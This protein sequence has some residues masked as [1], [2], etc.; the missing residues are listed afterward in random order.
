M[1]AKLEGKCIYLCLSSE[2]LWKIDKRTKKKHENRLEEFLVKQYRCQKSNI[3]TGKTEELQSRVCF[4]SIY[5]V[6]G[7][8]RYPMERV[9]VLAFL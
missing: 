6:L 7:S 3:V 1:H 4:D 8:D 9:E 5:R 2:Q